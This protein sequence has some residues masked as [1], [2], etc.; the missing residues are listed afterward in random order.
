MECIDCHI[1]LEVMGAGRPVASKAQ[2][3]RVRCEDCHVAPG[4]KLASREAK[5]I[6]PE[7]RRILLL[8]GWA[9]RPG[10][11]AG[12]TRS[13]DFLY[14]VFVDSAGRG[15]LKRKKDGRILPLA[16][17]VAACGGDKAHER[18]TC[19]SCHTSWAPQCTTCHTRFD[20]QSLAQ[21]YL[22][23]K[24]VKGE[25][26]EE[27]KRFDAGPPA[28]GVRRAD[29][30]GER[31]GEVIDTFVPG[32]IITIDRNM[33]A[34]APK[35]EVFHRLFAPLAAHTIV[36]ASRSCRSC[37][38][39]PVAL[40]YGAGVLTFEPAPSPTTTSTP[41]TG[42]WRFTPKEPSLPQDNLPADAWTGFLLA[43]N[44]GAS[45]HDGARPFDVNE[46][47]RIL[48]VGACLTCHEGGSAAMRAALR[49]FD[50]TMARRT[51]RCATP[52]WR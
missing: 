9:H 20:P 39:D 28:L 50:G 11:R 52:A 16:P 40:G 1:T 6:D 4:G 42:T 33:T 36:R 34:G 21:D 10:E 18:L 35:D 26:V 13:G 41:R 19:N 38:N 23:W 46:Q 7:S 31:G 5:D 22:D 45:T 15:T 47:K 49:D 30:H 12:T 44:T 25:W 2:A 43:R 14:N 8:R 24:L 37:H 27:S 3:L 32:M 29:G 51:P 17:Q 48:V